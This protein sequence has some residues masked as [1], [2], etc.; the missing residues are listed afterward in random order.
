MLNTSAPPRSP[1]GVTR[2]TPDALF[3]QGIF[4]N[5][6]RSG[7]WRAT[8]RVT[9]FVNKEEAGWATKL[10]STMSKSVARRG[11]D[12]TLTLTLASEGRWIMDVSILERNDRGVPFPRFWAL[13]SQS[14]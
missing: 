13:H 12:Y 7:S 8:T 3:P 10:A 1:A 4:R 14:G 11:D 9:V 6:K 5:R 2:T